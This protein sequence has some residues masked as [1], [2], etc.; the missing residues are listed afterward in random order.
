MNADLLRMFLRVDLE[1]AFYWAGKLDAQPEVKIC[2]CLRFGRF[3]SLVEDEEN[4]IQ[5]LDNAWVKY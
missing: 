4:D 3:E 1:S 2:K 5:S